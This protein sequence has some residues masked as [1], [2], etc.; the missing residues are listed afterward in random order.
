M[1]AGDAQRGA[2]VSAADPPSAAAGGEAQVLNVREAMWRIRV[3]WL[4]G[5]AWMFTTTSVALTK[6]AQCL[7][8]PLKRYGLLSAL[9][10]VGA[11][12]ALPTTYF[13]ARCGRRK[14]IFLVAGIAHRSMWVLIALVPWVLPSAWWWKALMT[15]QA[16]SSLGAYIMSPAVLSWFADVVPAEIRGRFFSRWSQGGQLVGLLA[17][18]LVTYCLDWAEPAGQRALLLTI[19]VAFALAALMGVID[20]LWLLPIPD[21][22]HRPDPQITLARLFREPLADRSFRC[23]LAFSATRVLSL[24]YLGQY[25]YLY[26]TDVLGKDSQT[27]NLL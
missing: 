27:T 3:A 1:S 16:V 10:L 20:F 24:G 5:A 6:F 17:T 23:Y 19:S 22:G 11:V 13:I 18:F 26:L 21:V 15:L 25:V 7:D 8:L 2:A 4:F 14:R 12:S 9:P